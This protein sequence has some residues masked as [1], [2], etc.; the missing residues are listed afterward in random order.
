MGLKRVLQKIPKATPDNGGRKTSKGP[1]ETNI[2]PCLREDESIAGPV[3]ELVGIQ[4]DTNEPSRVIK[5]SKGLSKELAQQLMEFLYHNQGLG[6]QR[7]TRR[8]LHGDDR[9]ASPR[10][11]EPLTGQ[12]LTLQSSPQ[13]F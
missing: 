9:E 12:S 5:I 7:D 3:E 2:G 10:N 13:H 8:I 4:V 6:A 1:M 11:V